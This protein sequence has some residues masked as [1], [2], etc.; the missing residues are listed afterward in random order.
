VADLLTRYGGHAAAAGFS[1]DAARLPELRARLA[2]WV[3][4]SHDLDALAGEEPV[5]ACV[6]GEA[7]T[8]GAV[9]ALAR[10]EPCGKGNEPPRI[11][12]TGPI[13]GLRVVSGAH[14]FFR[15]GGLE[16]VW[17]RAAAHADAVR[18][19]AGVVG[20]VGEDAFR[21]RANARVMVDGVIA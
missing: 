21:G 15:V 3:E 20:V 9:R 12:V 18:A 14:L 1:L 19:A 11:V 13:D 6:P 4:Q 5:D 7:V 8:L 10:L 2:A 17:W 16:A